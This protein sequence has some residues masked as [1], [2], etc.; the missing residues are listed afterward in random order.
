VIRPS[1][2]LAAWGTML[3]GL[4]LVLLGFSPPEPYEWVLLAGAALGLVPIGLLLL[5]PGAQPDEGPRPLPESSLPTVVVAAGIALMAVGIAAG[6]WLVALGA[7]VF[8]LGLFGLGREF[9]AQR[10][11]RRR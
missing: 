11:E 4:A 6:L 2:V 8:A 9:R 1:L 10:R 5:V 7:E 3:A